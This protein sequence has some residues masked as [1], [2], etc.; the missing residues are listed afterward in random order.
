MPP[1]RLAAIRRRTRSASA[2]ASRLV[3]AGEDQ[4]QL[5]AADAVGE[6]ERAQ[7]LAHLVGD[8]AQ[9]GVARL[10]PVGVVDVLEAVQVEEHEGD[11]H[12]HEG[13]LLADLLEA[14]AQASRG[15]AGR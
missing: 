2:A 14:L 8:V 3:G 12:L 11:R 7:R 10:V 5:L 15:S 6:L 4:Q 9:D 1:G 13:R